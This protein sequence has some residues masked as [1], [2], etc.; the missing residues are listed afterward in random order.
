MESTNTN[1]D[2]IIF[3]NYL[4]LLIIDKSHIRLVGFE[5]MISPSTYT[6]EKGKCHFSLGSPFFLVS[7]NSFY[8]YVFVCES[9]Q[10]GYFSYE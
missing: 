9:L 3:F 7:L 1:I 6:Y 10:R 5:P 8:I 4:L 2:K